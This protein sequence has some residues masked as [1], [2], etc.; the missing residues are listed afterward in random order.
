MCQ[1]LGGTIHTN[2]A[3]IMCQILG[4]T[5]LTDLEPL[6]SPRNGH[7]PA[8]YQCLDSGGVWS[9]PSV[10]ERVLKVEKHGIFQHYVCYVSILHRLH[11]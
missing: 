3:V 11:M 1:I 9:V 6:A 5:E 8:P 10:L 7:L 2:Q 4:G